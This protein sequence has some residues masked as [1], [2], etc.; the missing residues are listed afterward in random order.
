MYLSHIDGKT[1]SYKSELGKKKNENE[2]ALLKSEREKEQ[3]KN[4]EPKEQIIVDL[5]A[6]KS[7]TVKNDRNKKPSKSSE[8]SFESAFNERGQVLKENTENLRQNENAVNDIQDSGNM[9]SEW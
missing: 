1:K 2:E 8:P 9:K 5:G 4:K 6:R 7:K 3:R